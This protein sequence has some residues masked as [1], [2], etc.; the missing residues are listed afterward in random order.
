MKQYL[1]FLRDDIL[2]RVGKLPFGIVCHYIW[3]WCTSVFFLHKANLHYAL[4]K[5]RY[6][7]HYLDK[8]YGHLVPLG[9]LAETN[10]GGKLR[11]SQFGCFGIKVKRPCQ[12]WSGIATKVFVPMPTGVR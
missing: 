12:S 4:C 3:L 5:H 6:L 11:T 9:E 10:W 8:H 2:R 7:T 1:L